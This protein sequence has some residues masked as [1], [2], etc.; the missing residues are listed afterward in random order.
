MADKEKGRHGSPVLLKVL[1]LLADLKSTPSGAIIHGHIDQML[2]ALVADHQRTEEAY[3]SFLDMLMEACVAQTPAGSSLHTHMR[4]MQLRLAPPL[5]VPDLGM[6]SRSVEAMADEL[7]QSGSFRGADLAPMLTPL[8]ERFGGLEVSTPQVV[9]PMPPEPTT[10][11]RS[12]DAAELRVNTAYRAH[13][14]ERREEMHKLHQDFVAQM[15]D[16][17]AESQSFGRLL[18]EALESLQQAVS[19]EEL[20]QRRHEI[21]S[22]LNGMRDGHQALGEKF[23][24]AKEYLSIIEDDNQ[25]LT[26]ELDRVRLLS[27]TDELTHLPN[28]RAFLRRLED[29]VSRVQRHGFPLSLVLMDL[30][31]F[32]RIN[33]LHGH[34]AGDE[35]LRRYA[36]EVLS[37]F[38]HHDLVARYG[39]EEF[40][41]LLPN[42]DQQGVVRA[43]K[44]V[45]QR[46]TEVSAAYNNEPAPL[47]SFSAGVAQFRPGETSNSLIERADNAL[48][49]AK[50][51]G[52]ER[53][54]VSDP[55]SPLLAS[56]DE[57]TSS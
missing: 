49:A 37:I 19:E 8:I 17:V 26:E 2:S 52:R 42:T 9:H 23:S 12:E 38:R 21:I 27:L 16:T 22:A 36:L 1:T 28:R 29:E 24:H 15:G 25:Q 34:S 45:Q 50:R 57:T 51:G 6:L 39:G 35:I 40:A 46:V 20:E 41:V 54:E 11:P 31:F 30:D 10:D 56:R 43:L 48:Y 33:D 44:K 7:G 13:L 5:S 3:A 47:P 14:D 53:I 18:D 4:L 55:D 32:K